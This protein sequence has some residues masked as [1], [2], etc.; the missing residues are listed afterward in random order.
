M[1]PLKKPHQMLRA[2]RAMKEDLSVWLNFL[3]NFNGVTYIPVKTWFTSN[4]LSLFT[5]AAGSAHLGAACFFQGHCCYL[6]WQHQCVP[7]S[8]EFFFLFRN[9]PSSFG[10]QFVGGTVCK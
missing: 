4:D 8:A 10:T 9:G 1:M 7:F 5:D 2:S 6:Q 3:E